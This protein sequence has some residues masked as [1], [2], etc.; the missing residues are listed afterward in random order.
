MKA[1]R[2]TR[3]LDGA[4]TGA[5]A[6][7]VVVAVAAACGGVLAYWADAVLLDTDTFIAA[8]E[9]VVSDSAVRDRAS[10][11]IALTVIDAIDVR[12]LIRSILPGDD[13]QLAEDIAAGF[14]SLTRETVTAAVSTDA[15][16][17]LWL[18]EMRLWHVKFAGAV[19]ASESEFAAEGVTM[20]VTLGPYIDL[21]T[22]QADNVLI[23]RLMESL[24][25]DT[26]RQMQVVVFDA[27]LV[28]DRIGPLR[29]LE[30]ARPYLPWIAI[31]AFLLALIVAPSTSYALLGGGVAFALG[32]GI[33][34]LLTRAEAARTETLLESAF[35]ASSASAG[36]FTG[37]LFGPLETW[38][39]YLVWAGTIIAAMGV[40]AVWMRSRRH[41]AAAHEQA[42]STVAEDDTRT[43]PVR[44]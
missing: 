28:A 18:A 38:M 10:E 37:A 15:F 3:F 41:R 35:S 8:I 19:R 14:E 20:R 9:P 17:E 5:A 44:M 30:A 12:A 22:E 6:L 29:E 26:V 36:R 34:S 16:K 40:V 42:V 23:R 39:G 31:S 1:R 4:R 13:S 11:A 21:L 33:A 25:P 7:L 24:V 32:G 27:E 43:P 2:T